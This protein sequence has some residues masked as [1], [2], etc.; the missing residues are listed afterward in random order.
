MSNPALELAARMPWIHAQGESWWLVTGQQSN[1][2]GFTDCIA[3]VVPEMI[4]GS[5]VPLFEVLIYGGSHYVG[6]AEITSAKELL[7]VYAGD[8]RQAFY[9]DDQRTVDDAH[10]RD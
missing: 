2:T 7:L 1:G 6:A 3:R 4:T 5:D 9:P 8:P 10:A